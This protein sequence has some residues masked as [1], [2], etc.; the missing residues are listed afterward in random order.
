MAT[1][2]KTKTPPVLPL[3]DEPIKEAPKVHPPARLAASVNALQRI[4]DSPDS[5]AYRRLTEPTAQ[6]ELATRVVTNLRNAAKWMLENQ[7][8]KNSIEVGVHKHDTGINNTARST[9][10]TFAVYARVE[11]GPKESD[12]HLTPGPTQPDSY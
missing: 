8:L 3:L 7:K 9:A 10:D 2:T 1:K 4:I 6:R 5:G 11:G 12:S